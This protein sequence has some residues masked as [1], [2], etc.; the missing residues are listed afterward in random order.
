LPPEQRLA[1]FLQ[2]FV[3]WQRWAVIHMTED[4]QTWYLELEHC[5]YCAGI[6][7]ATAPLCQGATILYAALAKAATGR[8]ISV[9]ETACVAAGD[10]HC[11]FAV[12]K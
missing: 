5:S 8:T 12:T 6:H 9:T 1:A 3:P 7:G 11:K 10:P 4:P 2:D